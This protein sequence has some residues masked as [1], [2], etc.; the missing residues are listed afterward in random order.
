LERKINFLATNSP[1]E[2]PPSGLPIFLI[3]FIAFVLRIYALGN[4]SFWADE[5][6]TLWVAQMPVSQI[7][8][9]TITKDFNPPLLYLLYHGIYFVF[10]WIVREIPARFLM[11]CVDLIAIYMAYRMVSERIRWK[12]GLWTA[13]WMALSPF[14]IEAARTARPY[15]LMLLLT[16][17]CLHYADRFF[18]K[19]SDRDFLISFLAL[20]FA[21]YTHYYAFFLLPVLF[22]LA[23]LRQ[24]PSAFLPYFLV[25]LF[26]L[27][28]LP[29]FIFHLS[30]GNP[31]IQPLS[32]LRVI[33]SIFALFLGQT[34]F[35]QSPGIDLSEKLLLLWILFVSIFLFISA[36]S[37]LRASKQTLV[38]F[39]LFGLFPILGALG[40]SLFTRGYEEFYFVMGLPGLFALFS[41]GLLRLQSRPLALS[42]ILTFLAVLLPSYSYEHQSWRKIV[43][44]AN[45]QTQSSD[46]LI[47][48]IAFDVYP[49]LYYY[50]G[51]GQFLRI[52]EETFS[53]PL[54]EILKQCHRI[55]LIGSFDPV[56][57]ENRVR[58]WLFSH[59][60]FQ[61]RWLGK[62]VFLETFSCSPGASER[63]WSERQNFSAG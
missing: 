38:F 49:V 11:V 43:E 61:Q 3:L 32:I 40:I 41:I 18:W 55:F 42:L 8:I 22:L 36:Y 23:L 26:Y 19:K 52:Q 62:R 45:Q 34:F 48:N 24:R 63:S 27:P 6:Y 60:P 17:F 12:A 46:V 54:D 1:V 13:L 14:E 28:W 10:P 16:L 58:L 50:H 59:L 21:F 9:H 4:S 39:V 30:R 29:A 7:L 47:A 20:L 37:G 25:F 2:A 35:L 33:R 56:L 57:P 44:V 5:A 31:M 15:I 53:P 51:K